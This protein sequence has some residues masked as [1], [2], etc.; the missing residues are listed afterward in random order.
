[1][2]RKISEDK[3]PKDAGVMKDFHYK[4]DADRFAGGMLESGYHATVKMYFV[5]D[6]RWYKVYFWPRKGHP[7]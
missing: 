5:R 3:I 1:M 2:V 7:K 4:K 6:L